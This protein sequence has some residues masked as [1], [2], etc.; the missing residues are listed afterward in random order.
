MRYVQQ[1]DHDQRH[2]RGREKDGVV[3]GARPEPDVHH[4]VVILERT[5]ALG[6]RYPATVGGKLKNCG[7]F[8]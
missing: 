2:E 6:R 8:I 3:V 4:A 5:A 1:N 7:R